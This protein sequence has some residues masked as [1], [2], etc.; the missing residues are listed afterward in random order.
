MHPFGQFHRY[1]ED[2]RKLFLVSVSLMFM[3]TT[4]LQLQISSNSG[5]LIHIIFGFIC[6]SS[7]S[8]IVILVRYVEDTGDL[9]SFVF[10]I[11]AL[12]ICDS[13][14]ENT[15]PNLVGKVYIICEKN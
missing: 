11:S 7:L 8:R 15:K 4:S 10:F 12:I 6:I 5:Q 1:V 3:L 2:V 14:G 13:T 9:Y